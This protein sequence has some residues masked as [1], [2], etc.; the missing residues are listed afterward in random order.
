MRWLVLTLILLTGL[1]TGGSVAF[2]D[3]PS[4]TVLITATGWIAG[5]PEGLV[6]T[7]VSNN[8]LQIDWTKGVDA[9]KTMIRAKYGSYP[10][11]RDDGYLVYY[12]TGNSTSD[13]SV[14]F[15]QNPANIYY[16]AWSQ[17]AN[18]VWV[19]DYAENNIGGF[20]VTLLAFGMI[21][22]GLTYVSTR[23]PEMLLRLATSFLWLGMAFW[24]VLGDTVLDTTESW[25]WI[26]VGALVLMTFV[27]LVFQMNTEVRTEKRGQMWSN[28]QRNFT[29]E[30]EE[31][32]YERY[33]RQLRDRT[34]KYRRRR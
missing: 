18:G 15:D 26:I 24:L 25:T 3:S 4:D 9:D 11:D 1:V 8:E 12:D 6:L 5:A 2:A 16:R 32:E 28:W 30:P 29:G 21:A 27:P 34:G 14:D 10:E 22:L 20:V 7:Y 31:T 17:N 23:R 19:D 33:R 13:T